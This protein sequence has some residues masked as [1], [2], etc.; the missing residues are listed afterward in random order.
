M[1]T[2]A[3][4]GAAALTLLLLTTLVGDFL[5]GIVDAVDFT[6]GHLSSAAVL[7]FLAVFGLVGAVT[8]NAGWA[9]WA[10][11]AAAV[12]AGLVVGAGAGWATNALANGPTAHQIT[13]ADYVGATA[14]VT[15]PIPAAGVGQV[16]TSIAGHPTALAA[17][18]AQPIAAGVRVRVTAVLSPGT[19]HVTPTDT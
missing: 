18:A 14:T 8:T 3:L 5:D 13:S 2:F 19:V 11:I 7:S 1:L 12:A 6:G 16:H 10:A 17:R 4:I 9:T 15:T